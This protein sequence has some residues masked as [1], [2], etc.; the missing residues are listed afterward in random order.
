MMDRYKLF[1]QDLVFLLKERLE[2]AKENQYSSKNDY[3]LGI[4][5][6]I[7]ECIDLIKQQSNTH[8]IP[9]EDLGLNDFPLEDYL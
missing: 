8:M 1:L 3:N 6:G 5:M 9:L 2:K 7:Y 4:S